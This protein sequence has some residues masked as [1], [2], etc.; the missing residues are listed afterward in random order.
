MT[1]AANSLSERSRITLEVEPAFHRR[2]QVAAGGHDQSIGQYGL[3]AI[4]VRLRRDNE[5]GADASV[6][7]SAVDPVLEELWR[8]PVDAEYDRL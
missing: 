8:N 4:E 2:L 5:D 7:L 6:A 3:E 1:Q